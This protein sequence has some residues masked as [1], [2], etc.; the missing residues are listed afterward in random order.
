MTRLG[1]VLGS[2]ILC[3]PFSIC[4]QAAQAG[5]AAQSAGPKEDLSILAGKMLDDT[6]TARTDIKKGDKA[7]ALKYIESAQ[8]RLQ[9]IQAQA[10]GATMIPVYQEFVSI[11]FLQPVIAEQNAKAEANGH[12]GMQKASTNQTPMVVHQVAGNYTDVAVSTKVAQVNLQAAKQAVEAGNLK[13]ADLAL[14]DVQGGVSIDSIEA[15]MPLARAR[16][17]LILA[18][19]A[20]ERGNYAE[21]HD[22]LATARRALEHYCNNQGAPHA[23]DAKALAQQIKDYDN[24]VQQNHANVVSKINAWWN[25]TSSWTPYR[26]A[27]QLSASR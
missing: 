25:E 9:Q 22:A 23:A 24:T 18:R 15:N 27:N 2:A 19:S 11:S 8:S 16:E 7:D 5:Q 13:R 3:V 20:A 21:V 26:A 10:H 6:N 14:A 4:L 12:T 1:L 17:N